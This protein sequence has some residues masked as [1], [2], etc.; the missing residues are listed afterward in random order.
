[1]CAEEKNKRPSQ[2]CESQVIFFI[3]F[4][5]FLNSKND[6]RTNG[7]SFLSHIHFLGWMDLLPAD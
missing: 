6:G 3:L 1:M 7:R 4:S 2:L 5:L